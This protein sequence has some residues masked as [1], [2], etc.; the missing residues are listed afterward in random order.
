MAAAGDFGMN[1]REL[2][3]PILTAGMLP[4]LPILQSRA[5]ARAVR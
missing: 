5:R 2:I 1:D 4:T 3:S